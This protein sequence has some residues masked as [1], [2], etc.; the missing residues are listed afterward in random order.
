MRRKH[1]ILGLIIA[2]ALGL[3]IWYL[4]VNPLSP[5]FSNADDGDYYRRALRVA[6]TGKYVD[7]AWLIRPPFHVFVFA[8][9]IRAA[10][11]SGGGPAEGVQLVQGFHLL[12]GV[13]MVPLCYALGARLF[14]QRAG[15]VF[16]AFWAV[17]FPFVELPATLFSE[18]LYLFLWTLHLW[19]LLRFDDEGRWRDLVFS[20]LVLGMAALTRSPALYAL[21]FAAPWL[22]WRGYRSILSRDVEPGL[23]TRRRL[24]H[25]TRGA[26]QPFAILALATLLVVLPWTARNWIVYRHL[27]PIDT[28][29][30]INLWLDLG[31]VSERDVK[32]RALEALP[33]AERQA[34]ASREARAILREDPLR[35]F[36]PM[37]GTFRHIWKAQFV[38]D[39]F[40]KRSF[41]ARP[42][43]EVAWLGLPG[44]LIW[45]VFSAAG[46][47]GVLHPATDRPF[48]VVLGLWL[49]YSVLTVL[50]F[51]VEP[52]YL[53]PIWL[54]LGLYGSAML[55][56][57]RHSLHMLRRHIVRSSLIA[58]TLLALVVLFVTYRNYPAIIGPGWRREA[59]MRRGEA[60][61][62]KEDF[63]GAERAFRQ[64]LA[65]DPGFVDAEVG[66]ALALGAQGRPDQA[67]AVI[68]VDDSRRSALTAGLL[69]RASGD[70]DSARELLRPSEN[71]AGEDAQQWSLEMLQPEP[72]SSLVLG[73]DALD[74]GYIAGFG[75]SESAGERSMRWL[76][77]TGA[78]ALPLPEPV[79]L[80]DAL[81]LELAGPLP[82]REPLDVVINERW[83]VTLGVAAGWREYRIVLPP[84][85]V[86]S[87]ELRLDLRAPTRLPAFENSGSDD[88]RPLSVMVHAIRVKR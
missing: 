20:G 78:V 86:G 37:W 84:D 43:R 16:A 25:A 18:P 49:V 39:Y 56:A 48:K 67:L 9:L 11:Q 60:A 21:A 54:L 23:P 70:L 64:A 42:L 71:R 75:G 51:H 33:Q 2:V 73:D 76:L 26:V 87:R 22:V 45:L 34:F 63:S 62:A 58:A 28:L 82:G 44:D 27:I 17:W 14:G 31:S 6:V 15:L 10:L 8:G 52:R 5:Q 13:L 83:P 72:R 46:I 57:P 4:S 81:V 3:R 38:E 35:P 59:A 47:A 19:L 55:A 74:L 69:L 85:L 30:P 50:I 7:D 40:L 61:Y 29:G 68:S 65:A 41:F 79:A 88:A 1:L 53:L 12:L 77:G 36:R 80:G 24:V 66:L 32:I